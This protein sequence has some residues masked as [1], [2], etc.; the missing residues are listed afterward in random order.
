MSVQ[1]I[2]RPELTG[3]VES[4]RH[5]VVAAAAV[6]TGS[7]AGAELARGVAEVAA[8]E[9]QVKALKLRLLAEADA[10]QVAE[11][12]ADT[13]TDAWAAK[14]TGST[15][16]VMAGGIWLARLLEEKYDAT[17]RAFADGGIDEAQVRVIVQAAER[18][19]AAISD[20][21][22]REAE[23]HLVAQAV[24]GVDAR[25]LRQR[26]RRMVEVV[27]KELADEH[28]AALL[29]DEE[30]RAE[31]ETWMTLHDNGDGTVSGRFVIPELH[32]ALLRTLLDHLTGPR[33]LGRNRAGEL[34]TDPTLPAQSSELNWSER[35]GYA[36]TELLEHLPTDGWAGSSVTTLV[37]FD[38]QHLLDGLGS[39][40][41]DT[42]THISAG[43][44]RRLMCSS[45][46]VPVVFGGRSEPLDVGRSQRL[47]T[48]AIR[49]GAAMLHD[50]CAAEGC[51]RAFA[52]CEM[53]H[54][55]HWSHGGVT[56]LE[57]TLPLCG[58]HHRRAHDD[59][60]DM[61]VLP[62]REVRFRWRRRAAGETCVR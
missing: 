57:N 18:L 31:R 14:L 59:R 61:Q 5:A 20:E 43:E 24:D 32:G 10:R 33:R 38:Y 40:H 48:E 22:R 12:T 45:G 51:E 7:L 34:V 3:C 16:A 46:I 19:P 27:S 13:G 50:T 11:T 23:E 8:L 62:N 35:L 56:S 60:F 26:A 37:R 44:A 2:R 30:F 9:S 58:H 1:A 17:R 49:R 28:E 53:H 41:L 25:R 4:A 36:F 55:I 39:A 15:R 6:P 21:N 42:G 54:T 52:W 29:G 47:V